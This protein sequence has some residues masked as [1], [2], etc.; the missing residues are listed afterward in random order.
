MD[1]S[2]RKSFFADRALFYRVNKITTAETIQ[3]L[4]ALKQEQVDFFAHGLLS[5]RFHAISKLLPATAYVLGEEFHKLFHVFARQFTPGGT[6]IHHADAL[7]FCLFLQKE[8]PQT[9][10]QTTF[11]FA[12]LKFE[13]DQLKK[14]MSS[15][16]WSISRY[17]YNPLEFQRVLLAGQKPEFPARAATVILWKKNAIWKVVS[18]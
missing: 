7:A 5:K 10:V 17:A 9:H 15:K 13:K 12:I 4:D 2:F 8:I 16:R 6:H 11:R 1:E 3:F 18:F 14:F